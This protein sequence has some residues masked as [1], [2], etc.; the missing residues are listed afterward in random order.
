MGH[1]LFWGLFL[2]FVGLAL[3]IKFVFNLEIPVLRIA[4]AIFLIMIGIRLLLRNRWDWNFN[5]NER[6]V[7]FRETRIPGNDIDR[8]EYNVIFGKALFDLTDL[9]ST[10]LPKTIKINTIF[11][12][13]QVKVNE[14]MPLM[15]SGD[16]VFAGAKLSSDNSTV[17]G[18]LSYKSNTFKSQSDCL[19]IKSDVIFGAF[20]LKTDR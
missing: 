11:G 13:T 17:F 6:D 14:E 3:I 19:H 5:P 15:I 2:I 20:E 8:S 12:G 9:D 18:E 4:L 16:A 1:G 7:I 10:D